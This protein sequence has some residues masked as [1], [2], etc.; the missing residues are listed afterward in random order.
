[1]PFRPGTGAR[2]AEWRTC[3]AGLRREKTRAL[4]RVRARITHAESS[5]CGSQRCRIVMVH[6][7]SHRAMWPT[8]LAESVNA[9][10]Q[11]RGP[12]ETHLW[13]RGFERSPARDFCAVGGPPCWPTSSGRQEM[14]ADTPKR[15]A[16]SW[17]R[18]G[19]AAV[20]VLAVRAARAAISTAQRMRPPAQEV[21]EA[22]RSLHTSRGSQQGAARCG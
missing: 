12:G 22:D 6:R 13:A 10:S 21:A 9:Q 14:P 17:A 7:S 18:C 1:M 8:C 16:A 3:A 2:S 4:G 11:R 15:W 5:C 20:A 19:R